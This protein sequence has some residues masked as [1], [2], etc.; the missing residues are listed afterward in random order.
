MR[1]PRSAFLGP[2]QPPGSCRNSCASEPHWR[3]QYV[4]DSGVRYPTREEC[5]QART[6]WGRWGELCLPESLLP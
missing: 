3:F 4:P 1:R 6:S 2:P 5:E